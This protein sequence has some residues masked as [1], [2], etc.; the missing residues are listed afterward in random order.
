[1]LL[2][3]LL[4]VWITGVDTVA[5]LLLIQQIRAGILRSKYGHKTY[6]SQDPLKFW[7]AVILMLVIILFFY[8]VA[9]RMFLAALDIG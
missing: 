9:L 2:L 3:I 4:A 5:L 1:M 6:R 7:L 8:Y